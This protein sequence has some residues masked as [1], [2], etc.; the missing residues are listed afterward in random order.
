MFAALYLDGSSYLDWD[1]S[2]PETAVSGALLH[3]FEFVFVRIAPLAFVGAVVG[4]VLTRK[5]K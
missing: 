4:A 1:Y 2:D 3:A 5:R